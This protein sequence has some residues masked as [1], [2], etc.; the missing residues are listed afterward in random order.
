[1]STILA[2]DPGIRGCGVALFD[3]AVLA[4]CAWVK[5]PVKKD[6][7]P[8]AVFTMARAVEEWVAHQTTREG[9]QLVF[10]H[11]RI[12][13]VAKSVGDNNDLMPLVAVDYAVAARFPFGPVRVYPHEW[14]GQMPK[15]V[16][17][18]RVRSRLDVEELKI[19]DTALTKAGSKGHNISDAVGIGLFH[20]RRFAPRKAWE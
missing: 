7:G 1:V 3:G 19:L 14:K 15:E 18:A 6:D 4:A 17:A 8:E 9:V 16:C 10:E 20:V 12:Y 11:P 2:L 5:N 13:T